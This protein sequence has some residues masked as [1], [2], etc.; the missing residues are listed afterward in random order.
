M[1]KCPNL[2]SGVPKNRKIRYRDRYWDPGMCKI[3]FR[4]RYQAL[5][6]RDSGPIPIVSPTPGRDYRFGR[7]SSNSLLSFL[8][9]ARSSLKREIWWGQNGVMQKW[10]NQHGIGQTYSPAFKILVTWKRRI[11]VD[12][13][14]GP[15]YTWDPRVSRLQLKGRFSWNNT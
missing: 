12:F 9:F 10:R 3:R 4:F 7:L 15:K 5:W 1:K 11:G 13:G 8:S 6:Y 14:V 2:L